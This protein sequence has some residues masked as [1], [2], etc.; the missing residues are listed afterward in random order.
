MHYIICVYSI[1]A[2]IV[3]RENPTGLSIVPML[4]KCNKISFAS[5]LPTF[6]IYLGEFDVHGIVYSDR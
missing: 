6:P 4:P 5:I 3:K 2:K 1:Y